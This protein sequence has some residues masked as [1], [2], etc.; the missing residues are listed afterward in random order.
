MQIRFTHV[1]SQFPVPVYN[2]VRW[3]IDQT[4]G[5]SDGQVFRDVLFVGSIEFVSAVVGIEDNYL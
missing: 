4:A 3:K 1:F 5:C 2:A